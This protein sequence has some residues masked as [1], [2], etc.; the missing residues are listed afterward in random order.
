[1]QIEKIFF[2][3]TKLFKSQIRQEILIFNLFVEQPLNALVF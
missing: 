1:M 3:P 2:P